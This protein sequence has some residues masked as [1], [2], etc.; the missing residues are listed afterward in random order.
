MSKADLSKNPDAVSSMFDRVSAGY[1]RTNDI[2]SVGNSIYW[3][4]Q[5][6]A[7]VGARRGERILDVAAGTGTMSRLFADGGAEVTALDFSQGMIDEGRRRHGRNP[8]IRFL[9]GD[10]SELPFGDG[11]FD[12]TT[13]S[14]GLRNVQRPRAA[15]AEMFRV[16]RPGGRIVVCEFSHVTSP[17]V[18]AGY[19]AWMRGVMP[20]LVRVVSSDPE[21]Y[22]YLHET[23]RAW[24]EQRTL[25]RW[26]REAGFERVKYRNLSFGIAALHKGFKPAHAGDGTA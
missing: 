23:I 26:I 6:R 7:A 17:A 9:R 2:L 20:G 5:T 19:S 24:P 14:F 3:R 16:T 25:A 13:I 8:R 21:A 1:D 4:A 12:A 10:A 22:D 11:E 15:L 18:R